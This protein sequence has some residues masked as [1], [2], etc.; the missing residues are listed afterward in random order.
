MGAEFLFLGVG[1]GHKPEMVDLRKTDGV[2]CAA[3]GTV[4]DVICIDISAF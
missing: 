1:L 2:S 4:T 3:V